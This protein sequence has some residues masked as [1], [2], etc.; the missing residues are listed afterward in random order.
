M[1]IIAPKKIK[2]I[3]A[4]GYSDVTVTGDAI[5][6]PRAVMGAD[7]DA[8]RGQPM[9]ARNMETGRR[10]PPHDSRSGLDKAAGSLKPVGFPLNGGKVSGASGDQSPASNGSGALPSRAK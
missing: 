4:R 2:P 7:S 1:A 8:D 9:V 6:H 5:P 10:V 3:V